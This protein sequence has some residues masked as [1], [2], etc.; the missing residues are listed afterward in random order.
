MT[1]W[2]IQ[3]A[4]GAMILWLT[5]LTWLT[6]LLPMN[7]WA[8]E[9]TESPC[10]QIDSAQVEVPPDFLIKYQTGGNLSGHVR[11][12]EVNAAGDVTISV[13]YNREAKKQVITRY[14][15]APGLPLAGPLTPPQIKRIY[16]Q[17]LACNFFNLPKYN[18]NPQILNGGCD[19][20]EV[21]AKG[22]KWQVNVCNTTVPKFDAIV[23]VLKTETGEAN[24][25]K[26]KGETVE[27]GWLSNLW[28]NLWK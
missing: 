11:Y 7:V 13:K 16:A 24:D 6:M 2:R 17:V 15:N 9:Q 20:L 19:S 8:V 22:K 28:K 23:K 14:Q 18:D 4:M 5:W 10:G 26:L 12:L 25:R 21:T 1:T 27:P 3:W